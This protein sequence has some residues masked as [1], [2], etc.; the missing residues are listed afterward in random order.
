MKVNEAKKKYIFFDSKWQ[1]MAASLHRRRRMQRGVKVAAAAR[2]CLPW[3]SGGTPLPLHQ[4]LPGTFHRAAVKKNKK[5]ALL[6]LG[7]GLLIVSGT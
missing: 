7:F 4:D 2:R 6:F 5:G 3:R 1:K